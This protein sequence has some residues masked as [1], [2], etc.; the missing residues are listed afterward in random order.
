MTRPQP[1]ASILEPNGFRWDSLAEVVVDAQGRTVIACEARSNSAFVVACL[2]AEF[3]P[4]WVRRGLPYDDSDARL[5]AHPDGRILLWQANRHS[6][7]V[8]DAMGEDAGKIG[9][10]ERAGAKL[11]A[12]DLAD[13]DE[14]IVTARGN[15]LLCTCNRLVRF[16]AEGVAAPTWAQTGLWRA[17]F[18]ETPTPIYEHRSESERSPREVDAYGVT[19]WRKRPLVMDSDDVRGL[20]VGTSLYLLSRDGDDSAVGKFAPDGSLLWSVGVP[21]PECKRPAV[22]AEGNVYVL[23]SPGRRDEVWKIPSGGGKAVRHLRDWRDGGP[24]DDPERITVTP[25]GAIALWDSYSR[26]VLVDRDGT[27]RRSPEAQKDLNE[28]QA[29]RQ[30]KIELDEEVD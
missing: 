14:L 5:T 21:S 2:D 12:L 29:K 13:A 22:D 19:Y 27:V 23:T 16:N 20:V 15:Y 8:L 26:L 1:T 25:E 17:F 4:V 6:A 24:V 28:K 18:P 7:T 10:R 30:R 9:E 3:K 11:A